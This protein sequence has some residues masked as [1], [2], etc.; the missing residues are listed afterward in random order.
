LGVIHTFQL[1]GRLCVIPV[2]KSS[3][4]FIILIGLV[5]LVAGGI[6][7]ISSTGQAPSAT[8]VAPEPF[9][10]SDRYPAEVTL[11]STADL[12]MLTR[13]GI[14]VGDVRPADPAHPF[15]QP[16]SPFESLI[17]TVYINA[18][19]AE[20]LAREGLVAVTIPNRSLRAFH[21][22]GPGTNTPGGWPTYEQF[23]TRM[24]N[25]ANAH[26][27]L[28]RMVSIGQSVQGRQ[29]WMLK[30]SDNPDL[31]EDE[32]EFKYTSTMHGN[33]P[34]GTEMT[35]RLA[36]LLV[37]S[38]GS[39][40]DLTRLENEMEI[41]LFPLYNP[42]GY[43]NGSRYNAHG[44]DLN[45]NFPDPITDPV[46]NPTGREP[47]T[48]A[49]MYWGYAHRV[50][51]GANYHTGALVV[52]YPWDGTGHTPPNSPDNDL[53]YNF[54]V[55]YA[56]RNPMIWNGGF[57][58][59][60]TQGWQWYT[61]RGGMQDWAYNWHGEHHITIEIS[62]QQPPPYT[63]MDTY[64]N[65]NRDA[66]QWWMQ[67]ALTGLRGLVLDARDSA[68]LDA[69]VSVSGMG[70]PNSVQTDPQV[71]DYH[72]M[73]YPGNYNITSATAGYLSQTKPVTVVS[74]VATV[75]N[76]A[77]CPTASWTV[78][79][80]VT[81]AGTGIPLDATIALVGSPIITH[82]DPATGF[83]SLAVCP[84]TYTMR[85]TAPRHWPAER[86]VTVNSPQTQDFDLIRLPD[87]GLSVKQAGVASSLPGE[88]ADYHLVV[89]NSGGPTTAT[90]TDT[91]PINVTWADTLTATQGTPSFTG[92]HIT[93]LGL[94]DQ[95]QAVTITYA[96]TTNQCLATGTTIFNLAQLEDS[97]GTVL[98]R[99]AT[100]TVSNA[101]PEIPSAPSPAN[102]AIN[103]PPDIR[104]AWSSSTDLNCDPITYQVAFGTTDPPPVVATGLTEASF[105][106]GPL[107][108][109]TTYNWSVSA[110]DGYTETVGKTWSFT[111]IVERLY[112]LPL[113][114]K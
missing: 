14:D 77:M 101:A 46:D 45:R 107:I 6:P 82:T 10:F 71:G 11:N 30:I 19:E 52:N 81:E 60:V 27:N 90:V 98:T 74:D 86:Q 47:E 49:T 110:S 113:I 24:Q 87:L 12:E 53:F 72:R 16:G 79:G 21:Q 114:S 33:E 58:N 70:A 61:I 15:P 41:W 59:G 31:E 100:V 2:K 104:L 84:W 56:I 83:Y 7:E 5:L 26:P 48:Q 18:A 75:Q 78:T 65:A 94:V 99:T 111:T 40:P 103:Q 62:N 35:L 22:Y 25:L 28:V 69:T 80:T 50:A 4:L 20:R 29:L 76:F 73:I 57:P 34:V 9:P 66:M 23:V 51:M 44:I 1:P 85:V 93:W 109:G 63:Q 38:Y 36:E 68:P 91:L 105:N 37:N 32:P 55:A 43:V 88:R 64:W 39:D 92:G 67:R 108:P 17:A 102:G 96:V 95:D 89:Q 106:P 8:P 54:S 13:L 112:Y 3:L 97:I 42:D